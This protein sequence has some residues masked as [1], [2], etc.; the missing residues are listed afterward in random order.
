MSDKTNLSKALDALLNFLECLPLEET[1]FIFGKRP[2]E[3]LREA[4]TAPAELEGLIELDKNLWECQS[5]EGIAAGGGHSVTLCLKCYTS[6]TEGRPGDGLRAAAGCLLLEQVGDHETI[7]WLLWEAK[8]RDR[9][10]ASH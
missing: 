7:D 6:A 4:M 10:M 3:V 2:V 5:C 8:R 9:L 1:G